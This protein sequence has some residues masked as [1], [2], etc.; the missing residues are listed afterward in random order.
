MTW[1]FPLAAAAVSGLFAA[2]LGQQFFAKRKPH[3]L[4]WTLAMLMFSIASFAAAMGMLGGWTPYWFRVYFLLGAII[5][6]PVLALG[7]LYL[8]ASRR[9]THVVS[10]GVGIFAI[11]ATGAVFTAVLKTDALDVSGR[12]PRAREVLPDAVLLL[13]RYASFAGFFVVVSGA[14]WSAWKLSRRPD[15]DLRRLAAANVL[16]AAGTTVVAAASGFA[17]VKGSVGSTIF[18]IGLLVGVSTMFVG[19]LKTRTKSI[20]K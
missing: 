8:L 20:T 13:A 16:I 4:A 3:Q 11:F 6:V 15:D 12:I 10:I 1:I 9:L 18:S 7:T 17:S 19:F 14:L 5:N 2:Q